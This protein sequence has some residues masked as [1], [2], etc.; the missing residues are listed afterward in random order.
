[1]IVDQD[2]TQRLRRPVPMAWQILILLTSIGVLLVLGLSLFMPLPVEVKRVL[3]WADVA[4]CAVFMAD[5]FLLLYLHVDR[6]RYLL[7]WGWLDFISSIPL[8]DPFR[9]GR[10]ARVVRLLR[11]F[12]GLRGSAGLLRRLFANRRETTVIAIVLT[13][14]VV[15]VFSSVAI[16]VA[17]EGSGS[18]IDTAEDAVWWTLSTMTTVGYGDLVPVTTLGRAVAVLTMF[19][20]IGVFGAFTA[21][22]ASLLVRPRKDHAEL[23]KMDARLAEIERC[24]HALNGMLSNDGSSDRQGSKDAGPA[25]KS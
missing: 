16:L 6:K 19:S 10:I 23:E 2:H 7:T 22:I 17:E 14:L 18:N 13:L 3:D 4:I 25:L 15:A 9:W 5:F 24:L 1:M 12:R 8:V 20:G 11:L 21:L